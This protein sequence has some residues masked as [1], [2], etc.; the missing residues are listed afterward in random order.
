MA[1]YIPYFAG[2]SVA[3]MFTNGV[4][5]YINKQE[6][7]EINDID[8]INNNIFLNINDEPVILE[9]TNILDSDETLAN[10]ETLENLAEK[11]EIKKEKE[12]LEEKNEIRKEKLETKKTLDEKEETRNKLKYMN[13]D[14]QEDTINKDNKEES[15]NKK[16]C[17]QCNNVL[18]IK[19]FTKSQLKKKENM[20]CKICV[21]LMSY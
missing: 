20:R 4:Y 16:Y 7:I 5:N 3:A 13:E 11:D 12:T 2:A 6:D 21:K 19:C 14:S 18:S 9:N 10:K 8:N 15:I 1:L 17:K